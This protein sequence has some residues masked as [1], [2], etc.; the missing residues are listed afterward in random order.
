M[1]LAQQRGAHMVPSFHPDLLRGV[2]TYW[3]EFL[4]AVPQ[5]DVVYVPIGQGS[6]A[7]SAI[8]AKLALGHRVRV[9]G[10]VSSHATTYADSLAAGRVVE[11]PSPPSWPTAWPA[12]WPTPKRWPCCPAHRPHRAGQ[13]RRS[14]RRHA[15]PV[16]RHP[17]RGR[18]RRRRSTGGRAA[19]ARVAPDKPW[20]WHSRGAMWM[21]PCSA[22]C[23]RGKAMPRPRRLRDKAAAACAAT[24]A[25]HGNALPRAPRPGL[26]WR[27]RLRPAQPLGLQQAQRLGA[28]WLAHG[29]R[30]DTVL[31]GTL[32]R[33]AQTLDGIA[34][35]LPGLPAPQVLPSLNEYD[36]LALIRAIHPSRCKSP[37][38]PSCTATTSACCATPLRSG[39]PASSAPRA[40]RA[41]R[42]SHSACA[43]CSTRCAATTLTRTCCWS[44]AAAPSPPPWAKCWAPRPR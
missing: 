10:V 17:Q 30:F 12:A 8:A 21:R 40:C 31:M 24:I 13:R 34:Q 11:A 9:V 41:G 7:C 28:H 18:R 5:L 27:R 42:I 36:S 4:R 39:W 22:K 19:R 25:P 29:Q 15:R 14:G 35:G 33:H 26:V 37:T 6:G 3:W 1:H 43:A 20:A 44:A 2:S 32:R 16:H 38:R 23:C